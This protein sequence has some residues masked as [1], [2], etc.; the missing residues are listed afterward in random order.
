MEFTQTIK[1]SLRAL[2]L[3]CL[4]LQQSGIA[5]Q[6]AMISA[7]PPFPSPETLSYRVEWRMV[8][9]G[10]AKLKLARVQQD[11][12]INL[13]IESAGLVSRLYR[14]ADSYTVT[15]NDKFCGVNSSFE[16]QE[17]KRHVL[18][19][20]QFD[21]GRRKAIFDVND[22]VK[23]VKEHHE[24]DIVPCTHE[25]IG[26]LESLRQQKIDVG[27]S[28]TIPIANGKKMAYAKIEAQAKENVTIDGKSYSSVR[29]EAYIFDNV[30]FRRKGS[31]QIWLTDD[32]AH[33]P[34][35]MRFQMG[36]PIG[37]I[38]LELEKAERS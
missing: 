23:N 5:Q 19:S 32:A 25:V 38:T 4:G 18:E 21:N 17:G 15:S 20:E 6:Q 10:A 7:N 13:N 28:I 36:F 33:V 2:T 37:N 12:Q 1:S 22:V 34:I 8:T 24:I 26:A 16:A 11:W 35:K 14:I 27:K 9:A 29:Y 31:L 3:L 30:V